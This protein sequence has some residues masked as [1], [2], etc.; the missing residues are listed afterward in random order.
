MAAKSEENSKKDGNEQ[1]KTVTITQKAAPKPGVKGISI[2]EI[3]AMQQAR[4]DQN[5]MIEEARKKAAEEAHKRK[6]ETE[7]QRK[8][9]EIKKVESEKTTKIGDALKRFNLSGNKMNVKKE[10]KKMVEA[11][12][13]TSDYKSPICCILGHVDTGKTKLLDK[14]RES[15]VQGSEVGGI[16]QQIGATFFPTEILSAKCGLD[17][18]NLPGILIID[19]PGH[20][21]FANLR[22]R[23]SSICNLAILVVDIMHGLEKQTLESIALLR[24]RR[25]PFVVALNKVDRIV[26]WKSREYSYF[27]DA[28]EFQETYTKQE[29]RSLLDGIIGEFAMHGMNARLFSENTEPRKYVSLVPTSAITAEGIPDLIKLI[30]DLCSKFMMEKMKITENT[31]CTVLEV[32]NVEGFGI[33]IDAIISN[34]VLREGDRIGL[35]GYDGPIVT[36]VRTLLLPQPL[37]ELRVKSQ[38]ETVREVRAS[39]GVKIYAYGLENALAGSKLYVIKDNEDEVRGMLE[40]D[41]NNVMTS[42]KTV[43][44]GI[45]VTSS[46]IGSLEA[47]LTFLSSENIP[48]ASVSLGRL[49][50]KDLIK[51]SSMEEKKY[52]VIMSFEVGIEKELMDMAETMNIKIF[53]AEII[54]HLLEKY[55]RY[56]KDIV[57]SDKMANASGATFPCC[58]RILPNCVFNARSPLVLGVE[59]EKGTLKPNTPVC[60]FKDDT[61]QMLGTV[62]SIEE[63]KKSVERA[64]RGKQVAIKIE[65]DRDETPR[66]FPRHVAIDDVIYSVVTR[67]SIDLLKEYFKDEITEEHVELLVFLKKKFDII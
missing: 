44:E 12:S 43:D 49:K 18:H 25:T 58:F 65:V 46:T 36:T 59:I 55:T 23:G 40:D 29:F 27:N 17:I 6:M 2:A 3:R 1:R 56:V 48:V 41:I 35:C 4:I 32:K 66:M 15:N 21:S 57:A 39:M 16:T 60:V 38:Y 64:D 8:E 20:E 22:S 10:T 33:T 30:L 11:K 52:R 51:V 62:T 34:G 42:I 5:K 24:S 9:E 53:S 13:S 37:K 14:L 19:T 50:K 63:K 7:N 45:H 47:L 54:Y 67:H 28:L 61:I 26:N 31:E